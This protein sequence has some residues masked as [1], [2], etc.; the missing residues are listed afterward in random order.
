MAVC[1]ITTGS[2][3]AQSQPAK[4]TGDLTK[5]A[6]GVYAHVVSPDGN[7]VSNSGVVVLEHSVLVFD[8]HFTPEGGQA[9]LSKIRTVTPKPVRYLVNSHFHP[10][11][12]H[13]NQV[14]P[15]S[16]HII[17][18]TNARRDVLQKDLPALNRTLSIA[19]SQLDKMRKESTSPETDAALK[20]QLRPQ[21]NARQELLERMSRLKILPPLL[22]LDDRLTLIEGKREVELRYVGFGHTDGDIILYLPAERVV[23]LGDLFFNAALPNTQDANLLEWMKS[24]EE[25]LRIDAEKFVPGHGPVGVKQDVREFL[26]YF[27]DLRALVE[28]GIT[29]GDSM[30]QVLRDVQIPAKFASYRFQNFFPSNV[31]KMYVELRALQLAS[32]ST[33]PPEATKKNEPEK[34]KP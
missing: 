18:S 22:T 21:I 7:A 31:Q 17:G 27:A 11:H 16:L 6:D 4:D 8:T 9:L 33:N 12:T 2:Q 13:G 15:G 34:P 32:T 28:P 14:F 29:R 19:Q 23:F 30:E 20:E 5:L 1:P 24:L 3:T 10:D 26:S 25:I